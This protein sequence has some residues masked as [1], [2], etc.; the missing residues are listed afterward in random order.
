MK[1]FSLPRLSSIALAILLGSVCSTAFTAAQAEGLKIKVDPSLA[2]QFK[3][4]ENNDLG[5]AGDNQLHSWAIMPRAR[6]TAD[7]T[8][9]IRAVVD[10]RA[11][12]ID[13]STP[14][15]D[16][17]GESLTTNNYMELRQYFVRFAGDMFGAPHLNLTVGRQRIRESQALW[18]N[19]DIEAVRLGYDTTLLKGFV[20]VG[21]QLSSNSTIDNFFDSRQD[22]LRFMGEASWH[23]SPGHFVDLRALYEDDHS[24]TGAVGDV[25]LSDDQDEEDFNLLW[26][27]ARFHGNAA[28]QFPVLSGL[29]YRFDAM[30]VSG[31][32]DIVTTAAA[33][34]DTRNITGINNRDVFGWAIDGSLSWKSDNLPLR[35]VFTLGY[36]YGS[37]D[38][39]TTDNK[40]NEFRQ[41]DL[42]GNSSLAGNSTGS[43][44]HYGEVL[45]PELSNIHILTV[46]AGIPLGEFADVNLFYH[47]Y[48]LDEKAASL[49]SSG[50]RA[51]LNNS[52][53]DIGHELDVVLNFDLGEAFDFAP[54]TISR[55][56]LRTSAG[57]FRAGDAYGAAA[58]ENSARVF[59]ELV[60]NF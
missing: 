3:G 7:I 15:E 2:M 22:R 37:G 50:I 55:A 17:N 44:Y 57:V 48:R 6:V 19:R 23:Y 47:Y 53:K 11:V 60:F 42:H 12:A 1:R 40:N 43:V 28:R 24:G 18:W 13:G 30:V 36:A 29:D 41:S 39:D 4:L 31:E 34:S 59:T 33:G 35:P 5:T 26:A 9:G 56:K 46:G 38:D 58:D 49:R 54:T 14:G 27:G 45:R 32:E 51:N 10:A 8:D 16:D 20:A 21:E 52:D 25:I